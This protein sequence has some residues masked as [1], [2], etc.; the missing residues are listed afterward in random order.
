MYGSI[1]RL[2]TS[3][4]EDKLKTKQKNKTKQ[5]RNGFSEG[6]Q[7]FLAFS[8]QISKFPINNEPQKY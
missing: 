4:S 8:E 1:P 5:T 2:Q 3:F 6:S 7:T